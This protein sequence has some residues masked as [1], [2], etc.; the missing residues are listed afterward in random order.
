MIDKDTPIAHTFE[1]QLTQSQ[2]EH[3]DKVLVDIYMGG[4]INGI[5]AM[6][7]DINNL[8]HG[9]ESGTYNGEL[10]ES[11]SAD[12]KS[13]GL[14][15]L[16]MTIGIGQS[17]IEEINKASQRYIAELGGEDGATEE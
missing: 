7:S 6:L 10:P 4:A 16:A 3:L 11:M 14:D 5:T 9:I 17:H 15:M 12:D 1:P 8:G 13:Q 2:A